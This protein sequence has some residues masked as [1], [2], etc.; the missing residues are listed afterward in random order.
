MPESRCSASIARTSNAPRSICWSPWEP[1]SAAAASD[2]NRNV[3][4]AL[5][6]LRNFGVP[7][8]RIKEVRDTGANPRTLDWPAPATGDIIEKKVINGQRVQAGQ[9]L[10]RIADHVHLWVI[11]D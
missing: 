4:G 1:A 10:Y 2:A 8:S 6:R 5:Q 11:A 3:E 7:E 9:E